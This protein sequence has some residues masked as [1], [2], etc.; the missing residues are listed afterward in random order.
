MIYVHISDCIIVFIGLTL[1]VTMANDLH[2]SSQWKSIL[3][4]LCASHSI[5]DIA[6]IPEGSPIEEQSRHFAHSRAFS[7]LVKLSERVELTASGLPGSELKDEFRALWQHASQ[8]IILIRRKS[9]NLEPATVNGC[10]HL[11]YRLTGVSFQCIQNETGISYSPPSETLSNDV[12]SL[13]SLLPDRDLKSGSSL[14]LLQE[15]RAEAKQTTADLQKVL[16]IIL[17]P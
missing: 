6:R 11:L 2:P 13:S 9:V 17:T 3:R 5:A 8:I 1:D 12:D 16:P 4:D 14:L 15:L 7:N 10:Y